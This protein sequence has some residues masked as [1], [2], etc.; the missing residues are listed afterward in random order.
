MRKWSAILVTAV[1]VFCLVSMSVGC[2]KKAVTGPSGTATTIAPSATNTPAVAPTMVDDFEAD[3]VSSAPG[4]NLLGGVWDAP[5]KD[6]YGTTQASV[7]ANTAGQNGA[8]SLHLTT[9]LISP[10]H[11]PINWAWSSF[12]TNVS[13]VAGMA[14]DFNALTLTG[15]RGI[16]IKAKMNMGTGSGGGF[17]VALCSTQQIGDVKYRFMIQTPPTSWTTIT[18]PFTA[19]GSTAY[20]NFIPPTWAT[21]GVDYKTKDVYFTGITKIEFQ[22]SDIGSGTINETGMTWDIDDI[23]LY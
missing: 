4:P 19:A 5:T 17:I 18:M 23:T 9:D 22:I 7:V 21:A 1:L 11:T 14:V 13:T 16:K 6:G 20:N 2:K 12:A 8:K 15:Y 3:A 10:A